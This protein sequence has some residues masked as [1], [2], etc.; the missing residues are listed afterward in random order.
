MQVK[1]ALR[2]VTLIELM[3]V[4]AIIGIISATAYPIYVDYV[5]EARRADAV[6]QLL[7]LQMAQEEYRLRNTS[8]AM[9]DQLGGTV[10][11]EFYDF[12]VTNVAAETY[13]LTASAKGS[14]TVDTAC[15]TMT[16][17]QNDQRSPAG[18]W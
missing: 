15:A 18:C 12:S 5:R 14:Q 3:I 2:G 7:S 9:L 6:S 16:L 17:N 1:K 11:S 8:Y 13:T 4:I 10:P